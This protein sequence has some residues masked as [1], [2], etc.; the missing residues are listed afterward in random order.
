MKTGLPTL[1]IGLITAQIICAVVFLLDV[2][3]DFSRMSVMDWHLVPEALASLA[4]IAGIALQ[5][6]YLKQLLQRKASLERSVGMASSA[7]QTIIESHFDEWKL[8]VSERDVAGLMV[9]GLS[10]SEIAKVRGSA[11]GTV[12]AHLNAIYRKANARNRAEVLSHIMDT[13]I[14]KPLLHPANSG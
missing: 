6:M 1:I 8:T 9:K 14:D 5:L 3:A 10:I 2:L 4:L 11:D 7:L 12:K 13:L